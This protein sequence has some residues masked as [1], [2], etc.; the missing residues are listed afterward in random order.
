MKN[1]GKLHWV[2]VK[3]VLRYLKGTSD[4]GITFGG[5]GVADKHVL[6]L[7]S[8]SDWA[9]CEDSSKSTS[10]YVAMFNNGPIQWKS[11]LQPVVAQ[12]STEA[13]YIAVCYAANEVVWMRNFLKSIGFPQR[14]PTVIYE[15]NSS[16]I[17]L[18]YKPKDDSRTRHIRVRF[19]KVKEYV[20]DG[21]VKL[22]AIKGKENPAD[23]FTKSPTPVMFTS[24]RYIIMKF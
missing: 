23:L 1:P 12:S 17:K 5:S 9:G 4:K 3:G 21:T 22:T 6:S 20:L 7:Y 14:S 11:K 2:G 16:V 24:M 19:H 8:D 15:D 13:E 18:A 10:G